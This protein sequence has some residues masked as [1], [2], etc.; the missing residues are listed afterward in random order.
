[1]DLKLDVGKYVVAVSGGVDSMVLLELLRRRPDLRLVV[2]HFDHGIRADSSDDRELVQRVAMSHNIPFEYA[3]AQLGPDASEEEARTARYDFLR[4]VCKK[5]NAIAIITAHHQD[6]LLETTIIN[7]LRG[8]GWRGLSSLRSTPDLLRPL[9]S[10]PK[11]DIVQYARQQGLVWHED[12]TNADDRHMRN[13][14]RHQIIPKMPS[15]SKEKLLQ[16]I[17]RQNE[18][19]TSIDNETNMWLHN[20]SQPVES[21]LALPRH[22]LI[23]LPQ[24][25]AHELLQGVLRRQSGKS[26]QRPQADRAVLFCKVAKSGKIMQLNDLWQLRATT[27]DII[28]EPRGYV[29]S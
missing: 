3:T 17:V 14:V 24:H 2:V 9:L 16:Y 22:Q 29:V 25:V 1:M 23:M 7:L 27:T 19:T 18:L 11:A 12:S 5:H 4:H 20:H 15:A 21:A 26:M 13:Y 8:T 10:Y 28:V 6:D